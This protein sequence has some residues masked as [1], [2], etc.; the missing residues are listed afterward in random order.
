MSEDL[1]ERFRAAC[2][3]YLA[4]VEQLDRDRVAAAS[5]L[6]AVTESQREADRARDQ[7]LQ[8]VRERDAAAQ[9]GAAGP[10]VPVIAVIDAQ[11]RDTGATIIGGRILPSSRAQAAAGEFMA[12]YVPGCRECV[13]TDDGLV[14]AQDLGGL[15]PKSVPE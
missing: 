11:G 9:L 2:S 1:E 14:C 12:R 4:A 6:A 8:V 10:P 3:S 15:C 7:L 13:Q 5:A